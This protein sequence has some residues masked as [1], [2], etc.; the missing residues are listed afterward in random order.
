MV[1]HKQN[2]CRNDKGKKVCYQ[3]FQNNMKFMLFWFTLKGN[4][5]FP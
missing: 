5:V 1:Y 4:G 3:Q 2:P